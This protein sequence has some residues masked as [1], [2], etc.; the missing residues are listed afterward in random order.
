MRHFVVC[1]CLSLAAC[2]TS[3]DE[4]V[5]ASESEARRVTDD[6]SLGIVTYNVAGYEAV[7]ID[8]APV[9][10]YRGALEELGVLADAAD[11]VA[12]QEVLPPPDLGRA[13]LTSA[14]GWRTASFA[15][16]VGVYGQVIAARDER[17]GLDVIPLRHAIAGSRASETSV[18]QKLRLRRRSCGTPFSVLNAHL[19][20]PVRWEGTTKIGHYD[21]EETTPAAAALVAWLDAEL[22]RAVAFRRR[23]GA[24]PNPYAWPDVIAGDLNVNRGDASYRALLAKGYV[25]VCAEAACA[26]S[27]DFVFV[28]QR[29]LGGRVTCSGV[30]ALT[31][32]TAS[33]HA[34]IVAR[35]SLR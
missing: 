34:P 18:L 17:L 1:A 19:R 31:S 24:A 32:V 35:C 14:L 3:A 33:D 11:V 13:R 27:F 8:K 12:L 23:N 6:C 26:P 10:S 25:D 28:K 29:E 7:R 16:S 30:A 4:A 9:T 5:D 22:Q 2:T 20:T 15:D 21:V